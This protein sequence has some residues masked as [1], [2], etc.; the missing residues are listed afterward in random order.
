LLVSTLHNEERHISKHR[1][2]RNSEVHVDDPGK[3]R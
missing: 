2:H 3:V 1:L